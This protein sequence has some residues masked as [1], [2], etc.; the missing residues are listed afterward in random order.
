MR[1]L[2]LAALIAAGPFAACADGITVFAASSLKGALDRIAADWTDDTGVA[3]AL[4]YDGSGRLAGQIL[5][6]APADLFISAAPEWMDAAM[7]AMAAESRR[8]ILA[9]GLVL[10]AHGQV[11]QQA[12]GP[13]TDL[14]GLLG[15][16]RLAIGQVDA[17]PAGQYARQALQDLGL[18]DQVSG[19]L[20]QTDSAGAALDLV[21]RG[22][23]PLGVVFGSDLVAGL[24][25][26]LDISLVGRFAE[27]S[28]APIRYPAALV[29]GA[30]PEAAAFLEHLSG[31]KARA[32]FLRLGFAE[33]PP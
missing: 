30:A 26:G 15:G 22:E 9:G 33:V 10:I 27:A 14:A 13:Q 12:I 2:F 8:N 1:T 25:A 20:A 6:G 23:A 21:A 31:P 3:V 7:P 16:G 29:A 28:H 19:R 24:A 18:W 4:N 5:Q 11:P 17:V 32:V